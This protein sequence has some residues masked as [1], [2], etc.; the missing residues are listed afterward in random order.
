MISVETGTR[1]HRSPAGDRACPRPGRTTYF[2]QRAEQRDTTTGKGLPCRRS[3][4]RIQLE[5][6][7]SSLPGVVIVVVFEVAPRH[8]TTRFHRDL[9]FTGAERWLTIIF[10]R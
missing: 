10:H 7:P 4:H 5:S 1:N 2:Y 8:P 3:N 9:L 6:K